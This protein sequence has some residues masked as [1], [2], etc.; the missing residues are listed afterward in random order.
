ML[1]YL[2]KWLRKPLFRSTDYD[3]VD[4]SRWMWG[5]EKGVPYTLSPALN[6]YTLSLLGIINGLPWFSRNHYLMIMDLE[7]EEPNWDYSKAYLKIVK[8]DT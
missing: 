5:L 1:K 7:G 4:E 3:M 2:C 8:H 6:V